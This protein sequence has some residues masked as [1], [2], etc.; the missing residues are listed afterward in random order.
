MTRGR[1]RWLLLA[2]A[3]AG[4]A[5]VALG[6]WSA[7]SGWPT[8]GR[9]GPP[10]QVVRV[11]SGAPFD[12]VVDTLAARGLLRRPWLLRAAARLTGQD[13]RLRAGTYTV[14]AG[15]P[16]RDLLAL[17]GEGR[18]VLARVTIPEGEE[19]EAAARRVAEGVG[20]SAERFLAAAD[21][22][23]RLGLQ[24][25]RLLGVGAA[26][27]ARAG[28]LAALRTAGP[29]PA[30]RPFR[31]CEG[32]LAPDTYFLAPGT[33]AAAAAAAVVG[34]GLARADTLARGV[35]PTVAALGLP[36]HAVVTLASIVEAEARRPEDRARIAAVYVNRLQRGWRLEADPTVAY[37]LRKRGERL[38][39]R[40]L[41]APTPYNTYRHAGL[42][43]GPIGNPGVAALRAAACP[44]PACDALYFVADGAGGHVFSR[45]LAEHE[46]AV[47]AFRAVRAAQ[48]RD[49]GDDAGS[50]AG[51][52]R[53]DG[54][55]A[56]H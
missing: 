45:T 44:D 12:A 40:D 54:G 38:Y 55:G 50:S 22:L 16:P 2:A 8:R 21:S 51:R 24:A 47:R 52:P 11:P 17:L 23:A 31:W 39:Y 35:A 20:C 36:P 34:L 49:A 41:E 48:G 5:A 14:P 30:G 25:R 53:L 56:A 37:A 33:P 28:S 10:Y 42:P 27:A 29:L 26:G 19:A 43:P 6:G 15:L 13:R 9:P 3:L 4:A 46:R 32:Y 7:W 1:R 18:A